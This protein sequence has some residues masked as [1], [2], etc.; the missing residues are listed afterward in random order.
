MVCG[1]RWGK[2]VLGLL[3]TIRGHGPTRS[4]RRGAI[5]G[6]HF[7][8]VA[9][10]NEDAA[11]II[12]PQLRRVVRDVA[13]Y[14]NE[15]RHHIR[16]PNGAE[17]TV[18]SA[19]EPDSL[20]GVGLDGVVLDEAAFFDQECWSESLRPA[21]SDKQGWAVF[22]STPKGHNWFHD[23]F[24]FAATENG[25]ER[26]QR[27]SSDNPLM[28]ADELESAKREIGSQAFRQEYEA[29]FEAVAGSMFRRE[30]FSIIDEPPKVFDRIVR[31][32]DKA[33]TAKSTADYS[34]GVLMGAIPGLMGDEY[35]I[36]HVARGQW[37]IDEREATI[38][39]CARMDREF[40][41]DRVITW[42]ETEGGSAGVESSKNTVARL[43]GFSVRSERP[44]GSKEVRAQPF[45]SQV[46]HG[47]VRLAKGN[48]N[49]AFMDELVMFPDPK[50]HDDQV[51]AASGAFAKIRGVG[52]FEMKVY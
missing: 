14:T 36:L 12:W 15:Q 46:E 21:L 26:W 35:Y 8:W 9:R 44:T 6:G 4:S 41:G 47:F 1:R 32:W 7:W 28:T 39:K 24:E 52:K 30:W 40:F 27:P 20:R 18:K 17:I 11:Q 5:D 3:A 48:W 38:L 33:A 45:A 29:D 34:A 25:W 31:Y 23:L 43:A 50:V 10:S 22:I 13:E 2:T 16:M 51:D 37:S 42:L 19:Q 49:K